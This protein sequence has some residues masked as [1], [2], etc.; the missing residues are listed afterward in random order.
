MC[1]PSR[2]LPKVSTKEEK[3]SSFFFLLNIPLSSNVERNTKVATR[4]V[5]EYPAEVGVCLSASVPASLPVSTS[6]SLCSCCV[7]PHCF[8]ILT[9][10]GRDFKDKPRTNHRVRGVTIERGA[11]LSLSDLTLSLQTVI[12][13]VG[14]SVSVTSIKE[15]SL[16]LLVYNMEHVIRC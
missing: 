3:M 2:S 9:T 10:R 4:L 16:S 12:M 8:H 15:C 7:L 1:P 11:G 13:N 6:Q 14:E 5:E